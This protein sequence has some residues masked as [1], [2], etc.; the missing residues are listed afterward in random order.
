MSQPVTQSE[1][2][3]RSWRDPY[4]IALVIKGYVEFK[5]A[6]KPCP[7]IKEKYGKFLPFDCGKNYQPIQDKLRNLVI[8]Y[9]GFRPSQFV[10]INE[11]GEAQ[12]DVSRARGQ[13]IDPSRI[14]DAYDDLLAA[15]DLDY[16]D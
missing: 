15:E 9:R 2:N 5:E 16:G 13:K 11:K 7:K 3:R 12:F 1:N 14:K 6:G 4:A 8:N 10:S